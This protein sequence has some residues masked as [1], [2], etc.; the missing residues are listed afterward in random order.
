MV[1]TR[2]LRFT[3]ATAVLVAALALA[4]MT[5]AANTGVDI[6]GFAFAPQTVTVHVG[7][8]VTWSNSD[9]R[10][11]TATA[12]DGSFDTGTIA[13]GTSKS[14]LFST[15]GTFGYHCKIHPDMTAS[16]VVEAAALPPTDAVTRTGAP[17]PT[18]LLGL[19]ALAYLGGTVLG[20]RRFASRAATSET[21]P[22]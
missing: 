4:P 13:N 5:S 7:D 14:V 18:A 19:L 1:R 11:H 20:R 6:A 22:G 8:T 3:V 17:A 2:L 15:A 9:A 21:P 10:S 16:V 12:D